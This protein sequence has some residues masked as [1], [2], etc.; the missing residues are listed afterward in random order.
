MTKLPLDEHQRI[1]VATIA[2][3]RDQGMSGIGMAQHVGMDANTSALADFPN[4][5]GYAFAILCEG[6]TNLV[7][8][9]R[10]MIVTRSTKRSTL[11]SNLNYVAM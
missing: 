7:K 11:T 4:D 6:L 10:L 1:K 2:L 5:V 8:K 3:E 9:Q